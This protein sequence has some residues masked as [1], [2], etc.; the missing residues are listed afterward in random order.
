MG[1]CVTS[2][3]IDAAQLAAACTST[4]LIVRRNDADGTFEIEAADVSSSS[5][6][7]AV[8]AQVPD[9]NYGQPVED[10]QLQAVRDTA[11]QVLAGQATFT[12]TQLQKIAAAIVLRAT[13][14]DNTD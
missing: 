1:K 2:K 4:S 12:A 10:T 9:P 8:D 7:S 6:Q 5:L 3:E 13:R 14:V 11:R